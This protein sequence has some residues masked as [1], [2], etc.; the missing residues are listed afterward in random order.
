MAKNVI[1]CHHLEFCPIRVLTVKIVQ[2]PYCWCLYQIWCKSIQ[3]WR[4]Y[5]RLTDFK[6]AAT[7]ILNILP[8]SFIISLAADIPVKFHM[9]TKIYV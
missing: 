5:G 7:A 6:M 2:G 4:S 3:K 9:C 1:F 8:V